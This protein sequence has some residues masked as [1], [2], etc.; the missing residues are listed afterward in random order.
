MGKLLIATLLFCNIGFAN[1]KTAKSKVP[2]QIAST[3]K[4]ASSFQEA[5]SVSCI[6]KNYNDNFSEQTISKPMKSSEGGT[7]AEIFKAGIFKVEVS[8]YS[9]GACDEG[10]FLFVK[11]NKSEATYSTKSG[12]ITFV[13]L[14]GSISYNI[15][16]TFKR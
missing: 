9:L 6:V 13:S 16:C 1:S 7:S 12:E 11:D 10:D 3:C 8:S 2:R 5:K 14:E 4:G 15:S